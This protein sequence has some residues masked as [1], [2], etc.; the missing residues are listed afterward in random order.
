MAE[1]LPSRHKAPGSIPRHCQNKNYGLE[2]GVR[3]VKALPAL[4]E[5][6]GP[7]SSFYM[8]LPPSVTL[9]PVYPV[10]SSGLHTQQV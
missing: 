6:T 1:L 10:P 3:Q 9:D 5:D 4:P 2:E 8:A 7:V